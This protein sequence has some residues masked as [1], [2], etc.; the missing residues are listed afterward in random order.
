MSTTINLLA[1]AKIVE[2]LTPATDAAGRTGSWV[3]GKLATKAYIRVHIAQGNAATILLTVKQA[4]SAAGAG[5]KVITVA[6]PISFNLDTSVNDTLVAQA[7][8]VNFTTDAG[9]KNKQVVFE[10]DLISILD[11]LNGFTWFTIVTGAS[12]LA[13]LT[14]AEAILVGLT[15]HQNPPLSAVV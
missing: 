15:Y 2:L 11:F 5:A 9:V 7:A 10:L 3:N 4:T 12:N 8:A 1:D 13:N 14:E 6:V